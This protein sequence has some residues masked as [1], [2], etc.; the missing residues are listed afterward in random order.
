MLTFILIGAALLLAA[1]AR[2]LPNIMRRELPAAGPPPESRGEAVRRVLKHLERKTIAEL[3]DGEAAVVVGTVSGIDGVQPMAA[4]YSGA[5]CLGYHLRIHANLLEQI[6]V[7]RQ[8]HDEARCVAFCVRDATG[9]IAVDA[10]GLELAITATTPQLIAPPHPRSV[11][12]RIPAYSHLPVVVE[13]GVLQPGVAVLVC[14]VVS[15]ELTATDYRDGKAN[16]M[17][18]ASVTFP[19]VASTDA[20]LFVESDRPI[21]PA[22]LH[23]R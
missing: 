10:Q 22:E 1:A 18:R 17:L 12:A 15:R 11:V 13:E 20:D 6:L 9:V 23:R 3:A 5:P 16:L 8:L 7:R 21:A 19:L 14:G 2:A 4:P